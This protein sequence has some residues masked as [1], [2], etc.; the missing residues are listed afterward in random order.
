MQSGVLGYA[1]HLQST[2]QW[3]TNRFTALGLSKQEAFEEWKR[4]FN[5][6]ITMNYMAMA[7]TAFKLADYSGDIYAIMLRATIGLLLIALN[8]WSSVSTFEVLGEFGWFV[9]LV[10]A[11]LCSFSPGSMAISLLRRFLHACT[12]LASTAT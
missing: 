2:K 9:F 6:C 4:I 12:T 10:V 1:L 3:W 11:A 7:A 5:L 8:V